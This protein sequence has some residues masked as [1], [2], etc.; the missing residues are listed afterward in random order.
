MTADEKDLLKKIET[1]SEVADD[2]GLEKTQEVVEPGAEKKETAELGKPETRAGKEV[3]P[4]SEQVIVSKPQAQEPTQV[5]VKKDPIL[6][7]IENILADNLSEIFIK[8]PDDK[9]LA[10]KQEGEEVA[11]KINQMIAGGKIKIS[12]IL[13]WISEWLKMIPGVNKYFIDQEAKIKADNVMKY[14]KEKNKA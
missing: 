10:F 9:K 3:T 13:D 14:A 8:L 4:E 5:P 11:G 6:E 7:D 2:L 1:T 12:K